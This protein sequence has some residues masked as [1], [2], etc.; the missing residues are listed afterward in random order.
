[1]IREQQ[2]IAKA[3]YGVASGMVALVVA[4]AYWFFAL[5]LNPDF[6]LGVNSLGNIKC[7]VVFVGLFLAVFIFSYSIMLKCNIKVISNVYLNGIVGLGLLISFG[8]LVKPFFENAWVFP[9]FVTIICGIGWVAI[10]MKSIHKEKADTTNFNARILIIFF[11]ILWGIAAASSNTFS[12][13]MRGSAYDVHHSSAY[14]DSIYNVYKHIEFH[15]GITDQY[16][17]YGLFF[18]LP[19]KIF[20]LS[21][22]TIAGV[23]GV[24][25]G[26]T[27]IFA[28]ISFCRIVRSNI[29]RYLIIVVAGVYPVSSILVNIFWQVYP[30]RILFPAITIFLVTC[31][32]KEKISVWKRCI[33]ILIMMAAVMWN[34]ESGIVCCL[35]WAAFRGIDV[36]QNQNVSFKSMGCVM[37]RIAG[38]VMIP[39]FGAYVIINIYNLACAGTG[40]LLGVRGF[41]G[42]VVDKSYITALQ[43]SLTWGN[44]TYLHKV[45]VFLGCLSWGILH[46]RL[47]GRRGT[48][49]KAE[50]A[51]VVGIIG[52]GMITYYINRT[53]A[54]DS[55]V[56]L[57]FVICLGLILDGIEKVSKIKDLQ[58][59]VHIYIIIKFVLGVYAL[60]VLLGC[61]LQSLEQYQRWVAK[62]DT[63]AYSYEDFQI[64]AQEVEQNVPRDTW[65]IGDGTSA[66]YME[67]GWEKGT[68]GFGGTQADEIPEHDEVFVNNRQYGKVPT[69]Y[70]LEHEFVYNDVI[71]G[72]FIK[73]EIGGNWT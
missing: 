29:I 47:F 3:C 53:L 72:Y 6:G 55:M 60:A 7:Y 2:E 70:R 49:K 31:F 41:L 68:W 43:T 58:K 14:I 13:V 48:K 40:A 37:A 44:M 10:Y 61:S 67:L 9:T 63:K 45:I 18:Y 35:A 4:L 32:N 22:K 33:A 62:Y 11:G 12:P 59:T 51:V 71:F 54:G 27:Y 73:N 28:M 50:Y 42:N 38:V 36:L 65:A 21:T 1:M 56:N 15:G 34:F 19:L 16:G 8:I 25:S 17:H 66:L 39:V 26:A 23:C 46:N 5:E 64:F 69:Y 20:G 30:H 57:F 24:L 52:I